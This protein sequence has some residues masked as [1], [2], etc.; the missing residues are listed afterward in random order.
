MRRLAMA[1][2]SVALVVAGT[3]TAAGAASAPKA[4]PGATYQ[5][6]G[7][8]LTVD[9]SGTT[10]RVLAL[11]VHAKCK[12]KAPTNEGDYSPSGLG[13][14]TIAADGTFTNVAKGD[15]PGATQSV[16][17]GRFAGAKVSG[18]IVEPA[19]EDKGFDCARYRGA[20]KASRV[21]GSGDT[22][23]P[24]A[25]YA[26]DDFSDAKSGFDTFNESGAYAEYLSDSRFRIGTRVPTAVASLRAQPTTAAADAAVTTGY[27]AGAAGDGAG[28][29]CLGSDAT[30]FLAGYVSVDGYAYLVHYSGGDVVE[31][32]EAQALPA[33]LLRTGPQSQNDVRLV[34]TPSPN[35]DH[36]NLSLS[37]NGTEVSNA[38]ASIG[39]T[40]RVGVFVASSSGTSEFTFSDF[41]VRKPKQ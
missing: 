22:T 11:P 31:S 3:P 14:F 12:G 5:G 24:G 32:R 38:E 18:T 36:T 39:G 25:A 37:L 21:K 15:E 10:V 33:G 19:F 26:K 27:T 30:T 8:E 40:G 7:T 41:V 9:A 1:I 35:A 2:G 20:W 6:A 13:P 29:A 28:L 4:V 16:I 23:A 34:C 17:K